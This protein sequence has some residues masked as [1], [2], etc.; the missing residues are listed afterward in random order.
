MCLNARS[1]A[2]SRQVAST[3]RGVQ[4]FHHA[5]QAPCPEETETAEL[6]TVVDVLVRTTNLYADSLGV[7][8]AVRNHLGN[9]ALIAYNGSDR[10]TP[11]A[12]KEPSPRE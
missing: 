3:E 8:G 4:V 5:R 10:H 6:A 1:L 12:S 9:R 11:E 7:G 2:R